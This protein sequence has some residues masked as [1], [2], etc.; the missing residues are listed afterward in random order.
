MKRCL[1]TGFDPFGGE[2]V[3]PSWLAVERLPQKI[4]EFAIVKERVPTVFAKAAAQVIQRAEELCPDA[5]V[6]VGQAGGRDAVTPE[7][8][9]VNYRFAAIFDNEGNAPEAEEIIPGAPAGYFS[10]LPVRKMVLAIRERGILARVS[11]TA[12]TFVCNE[13][14][15]CLSHRFDDTAV[16]VGFIHVPFLPEQAKNGE[17]SLPLEETVEALCAAIGAID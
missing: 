6:C 12:G 15:Y 11:A 5:I 10:T 13:L 17:A 9:A 3:N 7:M 16:K 14:F 2:T 1:V 4:G 8:I